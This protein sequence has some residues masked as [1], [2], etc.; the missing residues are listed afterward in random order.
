[1]AATCNRGSWALWQGWSSAFGNQCCGSQECQEGVQHLSEWFCLPV[2]LFRPAVQR[3]Q[4]VWE[5]EG[6]TDLS[7]PPRRGL[8]VLALVSRAATGHPSSLQVA[9]APLQQMSGDPA[10]TTP[11][12]IELQEM[13]DAQDEADQSSRGASRHSSSAELMQGRL[14][15]DGFPGGFC[16]TG[17]DF[18]AVLKEQ[19]HCVGFRACIGCDVSCHSSPATFVHRRFTGNG[20]P[21]RV[22]DLQSSLNGSKRTPV[23]QR[24]APPALVGRQPAASWV[25]CLPWQEPASPQFTLGSSMITLSWVRQ[26]LCSQNLT[27]LANDLSAHPQPVPLVQ[28]PWQRVC[29]PGWRDWLGGSSRPRLSRALPLLC[30]VACRAG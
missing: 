3:Q 2:R 4:R 26:V 7:A 11:G 20:F 6:R 10:P 12:E 14:N 9:A 24:Q 5:D 16:H 21:G 29:V 15:E 19:Q 25:C 8:P 17:A 23:Q 1:M 27:W 18:V 22:L 28:H 30:R 13:P